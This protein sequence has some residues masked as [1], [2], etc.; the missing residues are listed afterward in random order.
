MYAMAPASHVYHLMIG[1]GLTLCQE[2][3]IGAFTPG[4]RG[5]DWKFLTEKPSDHFYLCPRCERLET[6]RQA[7]KPS[8]SDKPREPL[9]R[10]TRF[11]AGDDQKLA[12]M[13]GSVGP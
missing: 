1:E 10:L 2:W 3:I 13:R 7:Q 9:E 4:R 8:T 12:M 11:C 5:T 6:I